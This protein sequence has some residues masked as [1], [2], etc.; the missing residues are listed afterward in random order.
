MAGGGAARGDSRVPPGTP[1]VVVGLRTDAL[2]AS[3]AGS[4]LRRRLAAVLGAQ[5]TLHDDLVVLTGLRA[6]T[7][8]LAALAAADAGVDYAAVLPYPDPAAGWPH[9]ERER[10]EVLCAGAS[11]VVVLE[12]TRPADGAGRRSALARRDGWLRSAAAGA[13]VVTDGRDP[14]AE[15]ALRR[16]TESLGDEVWTI[17]LDEL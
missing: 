4:A 8:E 16:F 14:E 10:F 6:G 17:E 5:Q 11:H 3:A 12:R 2:V 15:L 1:W 13:V 9:A 7:E